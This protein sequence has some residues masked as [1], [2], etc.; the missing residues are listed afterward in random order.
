MDRHEHPDLPPELGPVEDLLREN[1][2]EPTALDLDRVWTT[3][4]SRH[5]ERKPR[6]RNLIMNLRPVAAAGLTLVV[7]ASGTGATL[8]V[9]GQ[10]SSK[11]Q[12]AAHKQY[13]PP[14][15]QNGQGGQ[16]SQG[17]PQGKACGQRGV[18]GDQASSSRKAPK[19]KVLRGKKFRGMV[20][21]QSVGTGVS[22]LGSYRL[23]KIRFSD[24]TLETWRFFPGDADHGPARWVQRV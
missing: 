10:F 21:Y 9:T 6:G 16:N 12:S 20:R 19:N 17:N 18:K 1:R 3:V 2:P 5:R 13:C 24:G 23:Y 8:A 7:M 4:Q 22:S 11:G 15:S 14:S